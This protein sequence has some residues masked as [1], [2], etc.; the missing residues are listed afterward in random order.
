MLSSL[1]KVFE[2]IVTKRLTDFFL[3][4]IC[5]SKHG[6]IKRR[7]TL[8]NLLLYNDYIFT[9]FKGKMQV[10]FI[11]F[12]FSKAFDTIN[13]DRLLQKFWK[14]GVRGTLFLYTWLK[15]YLPNR[16]QSVRTCGAESYSFSPSSGVPQGS[17]LG[18]FCYTG[19]LGFPYISARNL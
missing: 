19:S 2:S 8:T 17:N 10:D 12:D 3:L 1:A 4:S 14:V 7:S 11:Y 9:A 18:P 5:S 6:F 13:H 15:S 16:T